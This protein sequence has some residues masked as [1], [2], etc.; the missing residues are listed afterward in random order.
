MSSVDKVREKFAITEKRNEVSTC[1]LAICSNDLCT[2]I[3][4]ITT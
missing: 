4:F 2:V 1:Y 3:S